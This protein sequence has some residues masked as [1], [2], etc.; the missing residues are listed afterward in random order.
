MNISILTEKQQEELQDLLNNLRAAEKSVFAQTNMKQGTIKIHGLHFDFAKQEVYWKGCCDGHG[1][2]LPSH[3]NNL[4]GSSN[5]K[6]YVTTE[7][8]LSLSHKWEQL[9]YKFSRA[10]IKEEAR[11]ATQIKEAALQIK[12]A[13]KKLNS[14]MKQ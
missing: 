4:G 10:V 2:Y 3:I 7:Q 12:E 11:V 9:V 1:Y 8:L 14:R 6:G 13:T 5:D